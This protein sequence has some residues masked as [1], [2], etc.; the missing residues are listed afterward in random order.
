MG[1]SPRGNKELDTIERL[2]LSFNIISILQKK[3]PKVRKV[4]VLPKSTQQG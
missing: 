3:K 4:K 1:Y 2:M